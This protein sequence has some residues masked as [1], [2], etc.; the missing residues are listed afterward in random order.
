MAEAS[1]AAVQG[2]FEAYGIRPEP[3]N[4][5]N[6]SQYAEVRLV[7]LLEPLSYLLKQT[8]TKTLT[9]EHINMMLRSKGYPQL[10]GYDKNCKIKI[11]DVTLPDESGTM[12]AVLHPKVELKQVINEEIPKSRA[13]PIKSKWR[14]ANG[15]QVSQTGGVSN[16][17]SMVRRKTIFM[18]TSTDIFGRVDEENEQNIPENLVFIYNQLTEAIEQNIDVDQRIEKM[19]RLSDFCQVFPYLL[20]YAMAQIATNLGDVNRMINIGK[21]LISM[22]VNYTTNTDF[23][24]HS[25]LKIGSCFALKEL[26]ASSNRSY[27][28][29]LR[30]IGAN[31]CSLVVEEC[32]GSFP[33][34]GDVIYNNYLNYLFNTKSTLAVSYGAL[35]GIFSLGRD[36][37]IRIIPHMKFIIK[38]FS[39]RAQEYPSEVRYFELIIRSTKAEFDEFI[40][41]NE[42]NENK[43]VKSA[44]ELLEFLETEIQ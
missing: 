28:C 35:S 7:N 13:I 8:A 42:G 6:L 26:T 44:Q 2:L 5:A 3:V 24:A 4:V 40:S 18:S 21:L 36:Y 30:D 12:K 37:L 1:K 23:Y 39:N 29:M 17:A 27:D 31:I 19:K 16:S 25:Y 9:T 10:Y 32:S 20:Q 43:A 14:M 33:G 15:V 11:K 22:I 34:I 38:S 41:E